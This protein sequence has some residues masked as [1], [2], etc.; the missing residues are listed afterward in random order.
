LDRR[1]VSVPKRKLVLACRFYDRGR[2]AACRDVEIGNA[3]PAPEIFSAVLEI[4]DVMPVPHDSERIAF[5][6]PDACLELRREPRDQFIWTF[7]FC[8]T[9]KRWL[10]WL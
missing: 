7:S 8:H 4:F 10:S 9:A 3:V 2:I 6:E 1:Y 5:V